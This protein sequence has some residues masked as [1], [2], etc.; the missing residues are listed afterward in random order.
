MVGSGFFSPP[1]ATESPLRNRETPM[2]CAGIATFLSLV[3]SVE[4][5]Q[6]TGSGDILAVIIIHPE[7]N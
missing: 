2:E 4:I 1:F 7:T 6:R 5:N 3:I